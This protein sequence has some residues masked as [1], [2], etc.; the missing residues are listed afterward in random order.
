MGA[1]TIVPGAECLVPIASSEEEPL[2]L[3]AL[4][5]RKSEEPYSGEDKRLLATIATQAG[6]ALE[7]I[8]LGEEIAERVA[9]ERRTAHEVELA[10]QVQRKLFPQNPPRLTTL[11]YA[12]DCVQARVVGGDYYDFL[13]LAPGV[14]GFALADISGK[15]FPAALLMANLQANL[16]G[17]YTLAAENLPRLLESVNRLFYENTEPSHYATMFFGCYDDRTR[18]LRYINCGHNPPILLRADNSLERLPATA[19]VVGLFN[20]WGCSSATVQLN[21]GDIFLVYT[22]GVTEAA[23]ASGEEF[24]EERLIRALHRNRTIPASGLLGALIHDV[25]QFNSGEQGDDLTLV[26]GKAL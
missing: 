1:D 4:G 24:G 11:E 23:D 25:Q 6:T 13:E 14:V 12:G 18:E 19:T 10:R 20:E 9:T 7:H 5:P 8:H 21:S 22:D 3:L 2:G 17:R 26:V 15:G 16:R